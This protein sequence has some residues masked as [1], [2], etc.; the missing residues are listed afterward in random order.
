MLGREP[1]YRE[2]MRMQEE[3]DSLFDNFFGGGR[4][5][6]PQLSDRGAENLPVAGEYTEPVADMFETDNEIIGTIEM[7][8]VDK[9]D[10]QVNST[11]DG[12]EV[13]VEKKDEKKDED[14]KKGYYRVE[15]RHTGY[16]R[17]FPLPSY[18]DAE[19]VDATYKNGVLEIR[20]PKREEH[21]QKRKQIEVK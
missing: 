7:P 1:L 17:Y 2:L 21:K 10:I 12:I 4:S 16:Y 11:D 19:K 18:A 6:R 3:M 15:R 5:R 13:K 14:E 20:I 8:G 9:K